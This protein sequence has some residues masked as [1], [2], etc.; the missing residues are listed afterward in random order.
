MVEID[1]PDPTFVG[2]FTGLNVGTALTGDIVT[3]YGSAS[4]IIRVIQIVVS[5]TIAVAAA[6][7]DVSLA[8]RTTIT[9]GGAS[10]ALDIGRQDTLDAV[11]TATNFLQFTATP[12]AGNLGTKQ[13]SQKMFAPVAGAAYATPIIWNFGFGAG[14]K[15]LYLRGVNQGL[16]ITLN[17]ATPANASSF[18]GFIIYSERDN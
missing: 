10:T 5:A 3:L 13:G 8:T 1:G 4:K 17:G 11:T 7:F 16:A 14:A 6:H 9:A 12:V 18:T 15:A 2:S